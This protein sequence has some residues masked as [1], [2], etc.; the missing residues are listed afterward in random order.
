MAA[1]S[2]FLTGATGV[3]GR[4]VVPQLVAAGHRV[5][6]VGRS[7]AKRA[8]LVRAG[9]RPID[10]DLFDADAARRAV[11]GHDTVINLATH[12]PPSSK[13]FLPG[14]WRENSRIR[15]EVS[16]NL[17]AALLATGGTR[18]IQESFA[19]VYADAGNRWIDESGDVRVV[20]YNRALLDSESAADRLSAAGKCG[21]I[22]RFS[23]FYGS[24]SDFT[25]D[26]VRF[27]LR[28][29]APAFG[30]PAAY[31]SS[32][33]HD[34]AASAVVAALEV[35][36]GRY[37]VSDD[38]PVTRRDFADAIA[39]PLNAPPPKFFPAWVA[40]LG[41]SLGELLARSQ[42]ISNARF[43]QV[44]GWSPRYRDV[45]SGMQAVVAELNWSETEGFQRSA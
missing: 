2:I 40:S 42:R 21:V 22:L 14:A 13:S 38:E 29:R 10:T 45:W 19:P 24:D 5:T 7:D 30:S 26:A 32:L 39:A 28:G 23:Y 35:P 12:I 6:A 37:N 25:R 44:S 27:V 34:D 41:G 20:R 16:A 11:A 31:I 15:R 17:S 3:I 4:R 43:R 9:A 8:A 36:A 1:Q 18:L 33:H